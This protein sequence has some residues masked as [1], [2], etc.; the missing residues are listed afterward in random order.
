[1]YRSGVY[2]GAISKWHRCYKEISQHPNIHPMRSFDHACCGTSE[3]IAPIWMFIHHPSEA[4]WL[5]GISIFIYSKYTVFT[6]FSKSGDAS[7]R[8]V[9][10]RR[11]AVMGD[12]AYC[13]TNAAII[14]SALRAQQRNKTVLLF[15]Q[16]GKKKKHN[17]GTWMS[18]TGCSTDNLHPIRGGLW[19]GDAPASPT[20]IPLHRC[21]L[22]SRR[23][24]VLEQRGRGYVIWWQR[25]MSGHIRLGIMDFRQWFQ[26]SLCWG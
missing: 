13:R 7:C 3:R 5:F 24:S 23:R 19:A 25:T 1:M 4:H 18:L 26:T 15:E 17:G 8:S 21:V 20:Q 6:C 11:S 16:E 9:W 2:H 22:A 10:I 12:S 14:V